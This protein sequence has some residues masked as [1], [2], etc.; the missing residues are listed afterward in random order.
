MRCTRFA[1]QNCGRAFALTFA[2]V[3]VGDR[4]A[5]ASATGAP[6]IT[7]SLLP[8]GKKESEIAAAVKRWELQRTPSR[9]PQQVHLFKRMASL[10][11]SLSSL[12]VVSGQRVG[13]GYGNL[14]EDWYVTVGQL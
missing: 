9:K 1:F 4:A 5:F 12:D 10:D 6:L 2:M 11:E 8:D 14:D 13:A 7:R 3:R